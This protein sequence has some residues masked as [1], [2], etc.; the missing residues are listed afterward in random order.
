M[1]Y[2]ILDKIFYK[3]ISDIIL[4]YLYPS[5]NE[6]RLRHKYVMEDLKIQF[7]IKKNDRLYFIG[8]YPIVYHLNHYLSNRSTR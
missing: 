3:D 4:E 6:I 7:A 8:I 5:E 1:S 2:R